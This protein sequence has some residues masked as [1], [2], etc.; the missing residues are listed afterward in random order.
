MDLSNALENTDFSQ[1][2]NQKCYKCKGI[3]KSKRNLVRSLTYNAWGHRKCSRF[4]W[5]YRKKHLDNKELNELFTL[6][7]RREL[8]LA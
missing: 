8:G 5:S 1:G 3:I 4:A 6:Q 7:S 2:I